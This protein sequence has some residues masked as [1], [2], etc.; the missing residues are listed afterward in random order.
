MA[1]DTNEFPDIKNITGPQFFILVIC[2]ICVMLDGFDVLV[3]SYTA[4]IIS[5]DMEIGPELLGLVFSGGLVGMTLGAVFLASFADVYGRRPIIIMALLVSGMATAAVFWANTVAELIILRFVGGLGLGALITVLL[6]FSG[7]YSP[8]PKRNLVVSIM[9]S[10]SSIGAVIGGVVAAAVIPLL[11]WRMLFLCS[12]IA[13][14]AMSLLFVFWVPESIQYLN[15]K[16]PDGV[17][18]KINHTLVSLGHKP[19]NRLPENTLLATE[20]ASVR[21]LLIEQRRKSTILI[22][23]ACIT[24]YAVMYFVISWLPKLLVDLDI[25]EQDSI[26]SVVM[27]T[28]GGVVGTVAIGWLSR[29]WGIHNLMAFSLLLATLLMMLLSVVLRAPTDS[30]TIWFLAF[31]IGMTLNGAV[32]NL[33][34]LAI[35]IYPS[36]VRTTGLGWCTGLGRGGA[37]F[38]PAVAGYLLAVDVSSRHLLLYFSIPAL[39]AGFCVLCVISNYRHDPQ[40]VLSR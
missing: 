8:L 35:R 37:I 29:W 15:S 24:G 13:T 19:V 33:V 11:G 30:V 14:A 34:T 2:F 17:L 36:Q 23:C 16:R 3:I 28:L 21:S 1:A 31:F 27:L 38:S 22:W 32:A 12:G 26:K 7:E 40:G 25:P 10:G 20:S 9:V 39:L 18:E 5:K 4:P 6:T